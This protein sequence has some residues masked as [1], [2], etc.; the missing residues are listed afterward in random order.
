MDFV[1]YLFVS[2]ADEV[3]IDDDL[4]KP[5]NSYG[6]DIPFEN[7]YNVEGG[8]FNS[9]I[10][11]DYFHLCVYGDNVDEELYFDV[12]GDDDEKINHCFKDLNL[13][14]LENLKAG[15]C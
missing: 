2:Y 14:E 15:G 4:E 1:D 5:N 6:D 3:I 10:E 12:N 8:V 13:H 7:I 9:F 11:K